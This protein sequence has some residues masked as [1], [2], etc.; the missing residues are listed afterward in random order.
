MESTRNDEHNFITK[1]LQ[2]Y[3][4]CCIEPLLTV[5]FMCWYGSLC[6]RSKHV[7][8]DV[9]NICSKFVGVKQVGIQELYERRA[10]KKA[11]QILNDESHV[12]AQCYELLP[13]GA[14]LGI[15]RLKPEHKS[16]L[17]HAQSSFYICRAL[18][19]CSFT[20]RE[21]GSVCMHACARVCVCV[22]VCAIS[23]DI[24]YRSDF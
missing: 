22:C 9:V 15:L 12:L 2:V 17:S 18:L 5:S 19:Q 11:R 16:L 7:L 10:L 24:Q 20:I 3:Y 8:S 21:R 1:I 23:T 4:K 14:V 13:S 6:I